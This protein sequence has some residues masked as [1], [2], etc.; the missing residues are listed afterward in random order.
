MSSFCLQWKPHT[1][2]VAP[3]LPQCPQPSVILK[4]HPYYPKGTLHCQLPCSLFP[5]DQVAPTPSIRLSVCH[6]GSRDWDHLLDA[7]DTTWYGGR[8][9]RPRPVFFGTTPWSMRSRRW[10]RG[11]SSR[12]SSL[13]IFHDRF[14]DRPGFRS[15]TPPSSPSYHRGGVGS[16]VGRHSPDRM[17]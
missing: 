8:G 2:S 13:A 1:V 17:T 7:T 3:L 6:T 11:Y 12:R 16:Y 5:W 4:K 15:K 10:S 14:P 9:P